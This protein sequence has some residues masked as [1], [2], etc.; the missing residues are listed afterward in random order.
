MNIGWP[1]GHSHHH[2]PVRTRSG[3][4]WSVGVGLQIRQVG[5]A[6]V[7]LWSSSLLYGCVAQQA[8]LKQVD[9][10]LRQSTLELQ[11]RIKQQTDELEKTKL[12]RVR[13][14]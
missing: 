2:M 11:K 1:F 13:T 4:C 7:L 14:S 9:R 8:D 6:L 12:V 5:I 3:D 10:E